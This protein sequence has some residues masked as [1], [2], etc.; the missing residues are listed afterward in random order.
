MMPL[1]FN[2]KRNEP[3]WGRYLYIGLNFDDFISCFKFN[4]IR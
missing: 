4:S 2:L 3:P 1:K